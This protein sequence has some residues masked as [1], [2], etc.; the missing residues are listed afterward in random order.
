MARLH[1]RGLDMRLPLW[2]AYVIEGLGQIEGLPKGAF[3]IMLKIH[4]SAI[5]GVSAAEII[6]AIHTTEPVLSVPPEHDDW[7]G[8][9]AP[10]RS[11]LAARGYVGNLTKPAKLIGQ[12]SRLASQLLDKEPDEA[13]RHTDSRTRTRFN[14]RISSHR[15]CDG[16]RLNLAEVKAVKNAVEG[17]TLND[18]VLATVGG[19]L[20]RYLQ[21]KDELPAGSL[22]AGAPV[23]VRTEN[24]AGT[25]GNQVSAM[26]LSLRTDIEDPLERLQAI[27]ELAVQSKASFSDM[28]DNTLT[29]IADNVSAALG[30]LTSKAMTAATWLQEMPMATHTIVSNV[31]GPQHDMFMNGAKLRTVMGLGPLLDNMGLFHAVMSI[32]GELTITFCACREMLPDPDFYKECLQDSFDELKAATP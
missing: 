18:V 30:A 19:A 29:S 6:D 24:Q 15:V 14:R 22:G 1:A 8:E 4:H 3:A 9:S 20:R 10:S 11:R 28:G 27:H 31:P 23:S 21:D 17:V 5:D 12:V 2:E 7:Q 32:A 13:P 25:A 26:N 16:V